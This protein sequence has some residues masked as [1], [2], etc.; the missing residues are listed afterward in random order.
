[1]TFRVLCCLLL[2][3]CGAQAV[4]AQ[5]RPIPPPSLQDPRQREEDSPAGSPQ[6]EMMGRA[7]I[8]SEENAHKDALSRAKEGE[9]LGSELQTTFQSQKSLSRDDL[10]KLERME[11]LVRGIRKHAGGS[12]DDDPNIDN[13]PR[14][15][16]AAVA[17]LAEISEG[18]RKRVEKT[19]RHVVSTAVIE[20]SNELIELIRLIRGFS[21]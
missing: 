10:K 1:M 5:N 9:Q 13:P 11:K 14:D 7:A 3:A 21:Q 19:S 8:K 15:L 6:Q 4:R 18:L 16:G 17:R 20:Q 12:D 2:F